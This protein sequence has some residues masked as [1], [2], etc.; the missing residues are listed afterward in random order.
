[1]KRERERE[2][3]TTFQERMWENNKKFIENNMRMKKVKIKKIPTYQIHVMLCNKIALY[4][5]I[6]S[7]YIMQQDNIYEIKEKK[8]DNNLKT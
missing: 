7:L 3:I 1:M 8:K 2:R 4:S 5:Y 6:L